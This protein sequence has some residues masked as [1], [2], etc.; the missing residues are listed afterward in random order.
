MVLDEEGIETQERR[1]WGPIFNFALLKNTHLYH[2]INELSNL[3]AN[4]PIG[5]YINP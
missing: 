1:I 4:M 2:H 3:Y 5:F